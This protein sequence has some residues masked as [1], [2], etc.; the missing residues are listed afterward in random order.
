MSAAPRPTRIG[1]HL[2]KQGVAWF[3]LVCSLA[4][5]VLAWLLTER[6]I[7]DNVRQRFNFES[8]KIESSLLKYMEE[9]KTILRA[10]AGFVNASDTVTPEEW[11]RF[12][13]ILRPELG[14]SAVQTIAYVPLLPGSKLK[15]HE[16]EMRRSGELDFS[17][18]PAGVQAFHAPLTFLAPNNEHNRARQG[19]DAYSIPQLRSLMEYARDAGELAVS[20]AI[21]WPDRNGAKQEVF[22]F[23]LPVYQTNKPLNIIDERRSAIRGYTLLA[24]RADD[25]KQGSGLAEHRNL[26]IALQESAIQQSS[27]QNIGE[28]INAGNVSLQANGRL[29]TEIALHNRPDSWRFH[30]EAGPDFR[31]RTENEMP[32]VVALG[33]LIVDLL[34]F[35]SVWMLGSHRTQLE[36]RSEELREQLLASEQVLGSA[37]D[38][39]GEAF[40]IYGPDDRLVYCNEQYRS[41]YAISAPL[42]EPGRSFEEIIR[43]G[44]KNGEYADAIGRVDEW[45]E[46]RLERHR[47]ADSELTQRLANGRWVRIRERKTA[48]GYTVGIRMDLTEVYQAK[49]AAEAA[50]Q[51]KSRFLAT[52]SHE[53]RTPMNG[54]LGMAQVLLDPEILPDKRGEYVRTIL[55][56]GEALLT[57]L[58]DILDFSKIEA[59]R[60]S[61]VSVPFSPR[62]LIEETI[63]LF[64]P[65]A[66]SKGLTLDWHSDLGE[67]ARFFGDP[68]R[69]RQML[70]NLVGNAVKFTVTGS[71]VIT[72]EEIDRSDNAVTLRFSIR[73]T[74]PGIAPEDRERLFEPF[75]QLDDS[76]T[77][78]HG[79]SGLGLSIV[80]QLARLMGGEA[81]VESIVG[82]G[83]C[84]WFS[85]CVAAADEA[86]GIVDT[87]VD[88]ENAPVASKSAHLRGR[89]LLAEDNAIHRMVAGTA[90]QRLGLEVFTANDGQEAVAAVASGQDFDLI[91][92]DL[93]MPNLDG[94]AAMA[95]MQTIYQ[96]KNKPMPPVLAITAQAYESEHEKCRAAGIRTVITKPI[97]F[98]ELEK[99]V[100]CL[101]PADLPDTKGARLGDNERVAAMEA[102]ARLKPL[103]AEQKFDSFAILNEL[104]AVLA[105]SNMADDAEIAGETL[106]RMAFAEVMVMIEGLEN[107]I[108][109]EAA[110]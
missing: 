101:L 99:Q 28:A 55:R 23:I 39:I 16:A 38:A 109:E 37:I 82:E 86:I 3:V 11:N 2:S 79:G 104:K 47:R 49:E 17:V 100:T 89:V 36:R 34:L 78:K 4:L 51:A 60:F 61:L 46:E 44:A 58:N 21:V 103:L 95:A 64:A 93:L 12:T 13:S 98:A 81:G 19:F 48:N 65:S 63:R 71:I 75:S 30:I 24:I 35:W 1:E 59:G 25:F 68:D 67:K 70:S 54:I 84:F 27:A 72:S 29:V 106:G 31:S 7:N 10:G 22:T 56:A 88:I 94:L 32:V 41:L 77:R 74:G 80:R 40:V 97:N 5:T 15:A 85:I 73:D 8:R 43:Y 92:L 50:S 108:R 26:R 57:Q 90:L 110:S 107:R 96:E 6:Y 102:I 18:W 45:V 91:I 42:M 62:T 76:H 52:V 33:G 20:P 66:H 69:I 83:S 105:H 53:I 87:T 14:A 9:L